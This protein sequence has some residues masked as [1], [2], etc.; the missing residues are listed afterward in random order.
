MERDALTA[1]V[2]RGGL[3]STADIKILICYLLSTLNTPVPA[4]KM[5]DM[6]HFE[7]IAN[8]FEITDAFTKLEN[9]GHIRLISNDADDLYTIT[10]SGS[11]VAKTLLTSLPFSIREKAY[12]LSLRMM[13]RYKNERENNIFIEKTENGYIVN[14]SV[15]DGS[16]EMMTVRLVAADSQQADLI[17]QAFLNDA[18]NIY[19]SIIELIT[20]VK[21]E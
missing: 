17:K 21:S 7:G 5:A 13:V 18:S 4:H 10:P 15:M 16:N 9:N 14:C 2:A 11:D 3:N 20:S 6:L 8:Y 19:S 12:K 1:G